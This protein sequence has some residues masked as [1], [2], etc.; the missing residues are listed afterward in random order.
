[1]TL[2]NHKDNEGHEE[3][4]N[5]EIMRIR[6][7]IVGLG[8]SGWGIHGKALSDLSDLYMIHSVCE[9]VKERGKEAETEFGCQI[10]QNY[11]EFLSDDNLEL[12][13]IT[14]PTQWHFQQAAEAI[15]ADK[16]VLI[17]KPAVLNIAELDELIQLNHTSD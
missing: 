10:Y 16:H 11:S 1:M 12:V 2:V 15:R 8:R 9:P 14:S 13:V 4:L 17:E 3:E 6:T 7:G 5:G